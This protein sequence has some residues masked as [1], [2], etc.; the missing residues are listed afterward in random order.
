MLK[1]RKLYPS[2]LHG[3][4]IPVGTAGEVLHPVELTEIVR[5]GKCNLNGDNR[6]WTLAELKSGEV[7]YLLMQ[8]QAKETQKLIRS[9]LHGITADAARNRAPVA[10]AWEHTA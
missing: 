4:S 9:R 10:F 7:V 2:D 6:Q 3:T 5:F 8:D 1:I